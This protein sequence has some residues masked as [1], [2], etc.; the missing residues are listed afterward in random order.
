[1][2]NESKTDS[3]EL[4][5]GLIYQLWNDINIFVTAIKQQIPNQKESEWYEAWCNIYHIINNPDLLPTISLNIITNK[6]NPMLDNVILALETMVP[7]LQQSFSYEIINEGTL[8]TIDYNISQFV[9][10]LMLS[11]LWALA[12]RPV[13]SQLNTPLGFGREWRH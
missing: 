10:Y 1:M 13:I 11:R 7:C 3:T 5:L 9:A 12:L 6:P 8:T 2:M 4:P